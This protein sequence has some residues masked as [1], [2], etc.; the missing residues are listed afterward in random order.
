MALA[1]EHHSIMDLKRYYSLFI[2]LKDEKQ[3]T[4]TLLVLIEG[5]K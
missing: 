5:A 1:G 2:W 4:S 3:Q